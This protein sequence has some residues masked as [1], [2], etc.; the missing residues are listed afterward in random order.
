MPS[1][2]K[3]V[4]FEHLRRLMVA[5]LQARGISNA[6]V[7]RAMAQVPREVFVPDKYRA[8]AYIDGP[9]PI[10]SGQT[11]SQPYIVA[12]MTELLCLGP[13]DRVL[14]I[15][16]G[17]GYQSAVLHEI[18]THVY[19]IER[20]SCLAHQAERVLCLIGCSGVKIRT[21]DG[22]RG[23]PEQAPFNAIIV[24][25]GA[26][27]IPEPLKTQL[28]DGGRLVIPA[29]TRH[30]QTLYRVQRSRNEFI[31]SEHSGCVFVPLV[32]TC[33]WNGHS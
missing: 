31:I 21:G 2:S 13:R 14:E 28:A 10:G 18:T 15:G 9:L 29:G 19:S 4:D 23:W 26:P 5:Q 16:T 12:L 27:A 8:D 24:T 7:L 22:S 17:S 11:I 33:G 6:A 3:D 30:Y 20:L 25:A 32:G 1:P